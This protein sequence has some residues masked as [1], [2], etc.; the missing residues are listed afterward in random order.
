MTAVVPVTGPDISKP[1][2]ES[3]VLASTPDDAAIEQET[4][5]DGSS[6]SLEAG[7]MFHEKQHLMHCAVHT[8]NNLFQEAWATASLMDDIAKEL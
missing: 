6:S 2:Q 3:T 7:G 5:T 8:L 1:V 4:P